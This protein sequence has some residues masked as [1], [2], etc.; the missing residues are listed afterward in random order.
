M[1]GADIPAPAAAALRTAA[2]TVVTVC[3]NPGALLVQALDS[4]AALRRDDVAHVVI[5]GASTDGTVE[6][7]RSA[8]Q[9][10]AW[11][12]SEPDRGIYDA[13]NKGWALANPDSYVLYLGADDRVLS[14]PMPQELSSA[15]SGRTAL[16]YGDA[17]IGETPFRSRFTAELLTANTLHHQA[18]LVH[19]SV[20]PAPPFNTRY[21]V[22]GDWD[23]NV[24]L[25]K[26]GEKAVYLPSLR[27]YAGPEG[28]SGSRPLDEVFELV[29]RHAGW[30]TASIVSVRVM[31]RKLQALV[32]RRARRLGR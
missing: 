6:Y 2:L 1:A 30:W 9:R 11:W 31:K 29:R 28:V 5:D 24:R 25:W 14:L 19:K 8:P 17:M 16:I 12:Q 13:M 7:L 10:L 15:R 27:S 18:L 3:R 4:V 22:F 26:Q 20:H 23:F 32:N 21:R